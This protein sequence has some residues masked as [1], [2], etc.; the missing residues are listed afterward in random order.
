MGAGR[1]L[2]VAAAALIPLWLMV[3]WALS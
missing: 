3:A 2:L 1:R